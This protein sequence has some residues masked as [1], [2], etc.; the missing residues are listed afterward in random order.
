MNNLT[1]VNSAIMRWISVPLMVLSGLAWSAVLLAQESTVI[2][3]QQN[4]TETSSPVRPF[5]PPG[6]LILVG[7]G[8]VTP[9]IRQLIADAGKAGQP[10][11]CLVIIPTSSSYADE[12]PAEYW[13][14]PWL[15]FGFE[16]IEILH[17]RDRVLADSDVFNE[18]LT[19]ATA[20][21]V[22]GGDQNRF[23]E[24]YAGSKTET[25]LQKVLERGG[26]VGGTSAGAAMASK[27]MIGGGDKEPE[28]TTGLD[29]LPFAIVDQHFAN[30]KRLTRL[31]R[32]IEKHPDCVGLGIDESTAAVFHRRS[33]QI[34]GEGQAH[35]VF[36]ASQ[37]AE[38][39]TKT[40]SPGT[41]SLDWTTLVKESRERALPS[42]PSMPPKKH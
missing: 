36:P 19:R 9:E 24:V 27:I 20:V 31:K 11:S 3:S 12:E 39:S 16:S 42:L 5:D 29:L 38:I 8:R 18:P 26:V 32:A 13:T 1:I 7:G 17:T 30:R 25:M 6:K 14:E 15:E 34:V 28:I 10:D 37:D 35:L 23:A 2:D 41:D 4:S 22:P 21:W 33:M 40:L